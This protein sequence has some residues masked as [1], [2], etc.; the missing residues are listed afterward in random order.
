MIAMPAMSLVLGIVK[1]L[2]LD[3][4]APRAPRWDQLSRE[5]QARLLADEKERVR[6][7]WRHP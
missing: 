4:F 3:P 7:L 1:M 5:D 2:R 6:A